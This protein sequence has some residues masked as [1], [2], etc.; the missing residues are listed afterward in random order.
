MANV[1]VPIEGGFVYMLYQVSAGTTYVKFNIYNGWNISKKAIPVVRNSSGTVVG[2]IA[3]FTIPAYSSSGL[4]TINGLSP[5]TTYT[6]YLHE[7]VNTAAVT[8]V[9]FTTPASGSGES[10]AGYGNRS[11]TK[12]ISWSNNTTVWGNSVT[13]VNNYGAIMQTGANLYTIT[14]NGDGTATVRLKTYAWSKWYQGY[15]WHYLKVT[16]TDYSN[17]TQTYLDIPAGSTTGANRNTD[18]TYTSD[19]IY[20]DSYWNDAWVRKD[21]TITYPQE[22]TSYNRRVT[23]VIGNLGGYPSNNSGNPVNT[24]TNTLNIDFTIPATN[25]YIAQVSADENGTATVSNG[26]DTNSEYVYANKNSN[27]TYVATP[28]DNYLFEGWYDYS[29]NELISN[30]NPYTYTVTSGLYLVAKFE[31]DTSDKAMYL[32]EIMTTNKSYRLVD[33]S[34]AHGS[35]TSGRLSKWN[36]AST[37]TDAPVITGS[38]SA[39]SSLTNSYITAVNS[40]NGYPNQNSWLYDYS[41]IYGNPEYVYCDLKATFVSETAN[42]FT[43]KFQTDGHQTS[44]YD[45]GYGKVTYKLSLSDGTT[46]LEDDGTSETQWSLFSGGRLVNNVPWKRADENST[47][48]SIT[49]TITKTNTEQT[50]TATFRV[51]IWS[52]SGSKFGY[53]SVSYTFKVPPIGYNAAV[54]YSGSVKKGRTYVK[55]NNSWHDAIMWVN[56]NGTWVKGH[57]Y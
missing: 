47:Y 45:G 42:D 48:G 17:N 7:Y 57:Y 23:I 20:S 36:T 33:G 5:S 6:L 56:V 19:G 29:S 25:V 37:L 12:T 22:D 26:T 40:E 3:Q 8:S 2:S 11:A 1:P 51:D 41:G 43:V 15:P 9:T 44:V 13:A 31:E 28:E 16:Y 10:A 55:Y 54:G 35:G 30:S 46:L 27:V 53:T 14:D 50:I 21:I 39:P 49:H 34:A 52:T 38:T 24:F 18:I 32:N 4:L